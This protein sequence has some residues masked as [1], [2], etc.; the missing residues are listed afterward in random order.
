[1]DVL[2]LFL[3]EIHAFLTKVQH[4]NCINI[5]DLDIDIKMGSSSLTLQDLLSG[6]EVECV[7][8]SNWQQQ[9]LHSSA[10]K[11]KDALQHLISSVHGNEECYSSLTAKDNYT[12][13]YVMNSSQTKEVKSPDRAAVKP[14]C[15]QPYME[16][17][18]NQLQPTTKETEA[19]NVLMNLSGKATERNHLEQQHMIHSQDPEQQ[20]ITPSQG[21]EEQHMVHSQGPKQQH[22]MS[23]QGGEQQHKIQ[24]Q[25]QKKK[26]FEHDRYNHPVADS[27][28]Q[29]DD[30]CQ[31]EMKIPNNK[32]DYT[33]K[34]SLNKI[35]NDISLVSEYSNSVSRHSKEIKTSTKIFDGA[36][37]K[38][39]E[40]K[41]KRG[42]VNL[43]EKEILQQHK[44]ALDIPIIIENALLPVTT[45]M[46]C[47]ICNHPCVDLVEVHEH[48]LAQH[49]LSDGTQLSTSHIQLH[50]TDPMQGLS[51]L[52]PK[53]HS[54]VQEKVCQLLS[55]GNQVNYS[56]QE[57][58]RKHSQV[59]QEPTSTTQ[60]VSCGPKQGSHLTLPE[61]HEL[62]RIPS[63]V[64][65]INV[66]YQNEKSVSFIK[67]NDSK[68]ISSR[69]SCKSQDSTSFNE[70]S[71]L[72]FKDIKHSNDSN[73]V[74]SGKQNKKIML[75]N[76]ESN[77]KNINENFREP[78]EESQNNVS[79]L[80]Q[81]NAKNLHLIDVQDISVKVLGK[82]RSDELPGEYINEQ[83]IKFDDIREKNNISKNT[84]S[85][86]SQNSNFKIQI[87]KNGFRKTNCEQK[88]ENSDPSVN[89]F[90]KVSINDRKNYRYIQTNKSCVENYY[91]P[92]E[93]NKT[94]NFSTSLLLQCPEKSKEPKIKMAK[95]TETN[96]INLESLHEKENHKKVEKV[97]KLLFRVGA[98]SKGMK[99]KTRDALAQAVE[100]TSIRVL[101]HRITISICLGCTTGFV[102]PSLGLTHNCPGDRP[103]TATQDNG[104]VSITESQ[105]TFNGDPAH[106]NQ[107]NV[108]H[109]P[110]FVIQRMESLI[111]GRE[112][113]S[114]EMIHSSSGRIFGLDSDKD[115]GKLCQ[116]MF[117]FKCPK[118]CTEHDSL[119]YFLQHLVE[120][121]CVFR[122]TQCTLMYNTPEK[123]EAHRTSVHPSE[124][125]RTCP[126]CYQVF[127]K[128]HLRNKH[129]IT[130]CS[131]QVV[132]QV[133][134]AV[135]KNK[136]NL[137]VHMK[138]HS[139]RQF[140]CTECDKAFHRKAVLVRHMLKHQGHKPF[141]CST[142][143]Q[144]FSNK[145]HLKLHADRHIGNRRFSCNYC[146]KKFYTQYDC[147]KHSKRFHLKHVGIKC[148]TGNSNSRQVD[149][150]D[151]NI[152]LFDTNNSRLVTSITSNSNGRMVSIE[153]SSYLSQNIEQVSNAVIEK[154]QPKIF[155]VANADIESS[156]LCKKKII[157][158]KMWIGENSEEI[159][160]TDNRGDSDADVKY[161]VDTIVGV[162]HGK[163]RKRKTIAEEEHPDDPDDPLLV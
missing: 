58:S 124:E 92:N 5:F 136:Y 148:D 34:K 61:S 7:V 63:T 139:E 88:I 83:N 9:N 123:V 151:S 81:R 31:T 79:D 122:C 20:H 57:N 146:D 43:Q 30:E 35:K 116:N 102:G 134:G 109:F 84:E 93:N 155:R 36:T 44:Q 143:N 140:V 96:D 60:Q 39:G 72:P 157:S 59:Q 120:G 121:P 89:E 95:N 106:L 90:H 77:L 82:A 24:N 104:S 98:S 137:M 112:S 138:S 159:K 68:M 27:F 15:Q 156:N 141:E 132:C 97:N 29:S 40:M 32:G 80:I 66:G 107:D 145:H 46:V 162:S 158:N 161:L 52:A 73:K 69:F 28:N 111:N 99:D 10:L 113:V 163:I 49:N 142:C 19:A 108:W 67:Q 62:E 75:M 38:S 128:R 118:C 117:V 45:Q 13:S 101:D 54:Q 154:V 129:L 86:N 8:L 17:Q 12:H 21:I 147:D 22:L 16:I 50:T 131:Q 78:L 87:L 74:I 25:G 125:D 53:A 56:T 110:D 11:L 26:T 4:S 76:C 152:R 153:D 85:I 94:N 105:Y 64:A 1:M 71:S 70:S 103:L 130:K 114:L 55:S 160:K 127:E 14:Y 133:C 47:P 100:S 23:I 6:T 41:A 2:C 48:I 119:D 42:M 144:R 37:M 126:R 51:L 91:I 135:L 33:K 150:I 149:N 18:S 65:Q 115:A 3:K